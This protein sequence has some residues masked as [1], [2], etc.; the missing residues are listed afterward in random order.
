[1]TVRKWR[2]LALVSLCGID[3]AP[4]WRV[5]AR[6]FTRAGAERTALRWSRESRL[7]VPPGIVYAHGYG[8]AH[9]DDPLPAT[10]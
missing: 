1:M 8:F 2:V 9:D 4:R 7:A 10:T 6:R 5:E 3:G